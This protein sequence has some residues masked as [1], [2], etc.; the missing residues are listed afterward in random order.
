MVFPKAVDAEGH[1]I[2]HG[3]VGG[4]DGGEDGRDAGVFCRGGNGLEPEV[5]G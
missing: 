4:G 2:V 5:G 1:E 3:V